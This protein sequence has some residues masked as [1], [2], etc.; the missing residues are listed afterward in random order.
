MNQRILCK[1]L[2]LTVILFFIQSS[3]IP[4]I[5]GEEVSEINDNVKITQK[6]LNQ[7]QPTKRAL[8]IGRI[9]N[10]VIYGNFAVFNAIKTRVITFNPFS[11]VIY[12]SVVMLLTFG[13]KL[14][15]LTNNFVLGLF[16]VT[17]YIT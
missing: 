7:E 4:L 11:F 12:Y 8:I 2:A 1:G 16:N 15:I 17:I 6:N 9:E 14:G 5:C 3:V 13:S 10:L